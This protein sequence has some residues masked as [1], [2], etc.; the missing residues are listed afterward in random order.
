V[1][2]FLTKFVSNLSFFK[3]NS[4]TDVFYV[5]RERISALT[6]QNS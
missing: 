6:L 4:V 2:E 1:L 3:I 5:G